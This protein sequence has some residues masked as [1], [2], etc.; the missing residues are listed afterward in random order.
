[1]T[2]AE[3]ASGNRRHDLDALRAFAML[4]GIALHATLSFFEFPWAVQDRSQ[5][6]AYGLLFGAIH[7]FRMPVFF[8]LSGFFTAMLWRQRGLS[9]LI[10]HRARRILLP[11]VLGCVTIVPAAWMVNAWASASATPTARGADR[12]GEDIWAAAA[13]GNLDALAEH[14]DTGVGLGREGTAFGLTPLAWATISGQPEAVELLLRSGADPNARFRGNDTALHSA[15]F[16]GRIEC[17]ALLL[18][19]G[20]DASARNGRDETPMNS[21]K[22]GRGMTEWIA[23][24][25]RVP[26]DFDAVI[27]GRSE[28]AALL[29]AQIASS[30]AASHGG[31]DVAGDTPTTRLIATLKYFPLFHHLWFLWHLCLLVAGFSLVVLLPLRSP[32]VWV[33]SSPWCWFWLVPLTLIP[34]VAMREGG[35][36][37]GFGPD[38][39]SGVLPFPHVFLFHAIFFG[40]G[41]LYY[42]ARDEAG[43]LGR[44]WRVYLPL[45]LL[46]VLPLGLAFGHYDE[47][48]RTLL[49]E[50][51]CRRLAAL[52]EALYSWLM[53]FALMGLFSRFLSGDHPRIRFLSDSSYWLYVAH[54]P[55][56]VVG[57][58]IVR[59]WPL[60]SFVKFA[61][62][63]GA[64]T[65][66]LLLVYRYAIRY[67]W[68]GRLLN[69]PRLR[70]TTPG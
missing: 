8:V 11:L 48:T 51:L 9:G 55:L 69:G 22:Y 49:D 37:P 60:I 27:V 44:A 65:G 34:Q 42:G 26:I 24:L 23:R 6:P 68:V 3:A 38:L 16:F 15:A 50:T 1:M 53:V 61:L 41:A 70:P 40:F 59:D 13:Y 25:L 63:V 45:A 39:S 66:L 35:S 18:N 57:Q 52:L 19:A 33:A 36:F 58:T 14:I 46:V 32:P 2:E 4:L 31:P 67:T 56:V 43:R 21:L 12:S 29:E 47:W 62:L 5:H 10:K 17:V 54:L 20:A 30:S 64:V 7:G 28:V